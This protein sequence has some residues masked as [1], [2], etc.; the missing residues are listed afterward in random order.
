MSRE[1]VP[2]TVGRDV[3]RWPSTFLVVMDESEDFRPMT[4]L[5]TEL[6]EER[7]N[8]VLFLNFKALTW[9]LWVPIEV[10]K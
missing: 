1:Y 9:F 10:I 6:G 5:A 8:R 7:V 4:R 3:F 2:K